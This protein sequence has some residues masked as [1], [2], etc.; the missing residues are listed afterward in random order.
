MSTS[1]RITIV[2]AG[3]AGALLAC[4]LAQR[5]FRVHLYERRGDMRVEQ[6][7]AGRSINLALATRGWQGLALAGL[8]E[9]VREYALPMKGRMVHQRDGQTNFQ[10]YGLRAEEVIWSVHRGRLNQTLLDAAA[11]AGA[12]IVFHTRLDAVDFDARKASFVDDLKQRRFEHEFDILLGADG[13]GSAL[14]SAIDQVQSLHQHTEFLDHGYKELRID[15]RADG[16]YAMDPEALHIWPRGGYMLIALPNPD[17]SFTATLFLPHEGHPSFAALPDSRAALDFF[18]A[19]FADALA[20]MP[21]FE[22]QY[23]AHPVGLLGTLR[24]PRWH[25]RDLALLLGDAAHA[26]VPFHGQGMN[27]AFEDCVSLSQVIGEARAGIDW[28]AV[29]EA[30]EHERRPHAHAIAE[31]ALE[32]YLEMRDAVAD[33]R[34]LLRRELELAL[35][36]R[37]PGRF[38]PR[39]SLVMFS[40]LGYAEARERGRL[41]AELLHRHCDGR[42]SLAEVDLDAAL[43]EAMALTDGYA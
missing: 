18:Q 3:L 36:R 33:P 21:D 29:F 5:G 39:Y 12:E 26:I 16:D 35:A 23:A 15:P 31:M 22:S 10:T 4:L 17:R 25:Y 19:E 30:F 41:Q 34:Y 8:S 6:M 11:A 7:A 40:T 24:C 43:A 1:P 42:H 9:A 37:L 20:L 32:N 13:A 14:R 2:G 28:K 38:V 27:C